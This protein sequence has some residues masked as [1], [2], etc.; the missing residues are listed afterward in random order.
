[1]LAMAAALGED[2]LLVLDSAVPLAKLELELELE[3]VVTRPPGR[4]VA[5]VSVAT[6]AT[7]DDDETVGRP[8]E[9]IS[10]CAPAVEDKLVAGG[11]MEFA[12][13][14]DI[15]GGGCDVEAAKELEENVAPTNDDVAEAESKD[16]SIK[17]E[18]VM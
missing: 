11:G 13:E 17:P 7:D 16:G 14:D 9:S 1:M 6:V 4:S 3:L 5:A 15:D 12:D 8:K 18:V 2:E 10:V